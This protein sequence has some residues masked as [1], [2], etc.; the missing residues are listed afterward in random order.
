MTE[1]QTFVADWIVLLL[2][3]D[4]TS[5]VLAAFLAQEDASIY[6]EWAKI[7]YGFKRVTLCHCGEIVTLPPLQTKV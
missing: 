1:N 3:R 5:V 2:D 6:L 4:G 7:T